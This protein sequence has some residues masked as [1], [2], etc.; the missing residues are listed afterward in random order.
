[1]LSHG[2]IVIP[3]FFLLITGQMIKIKDFLY[4]VNNNSKNEKIK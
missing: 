4:K 3:Y 1:M 2:R